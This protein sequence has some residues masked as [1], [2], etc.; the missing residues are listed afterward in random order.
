MG[1]KASVNKDMCIGCGLCTSIAPDVFKIGDD[2]LAEAIAPEASD[3]D[4]A[5]EAESS[6][7]VQAITVE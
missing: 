5:M 2:G 1:K 7:P 6:C 3:V 4:G